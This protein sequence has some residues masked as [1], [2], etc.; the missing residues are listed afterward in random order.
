[1]I[2][3]HA[4]QNYLGDHTMEDVNELIDAFDVE[5]L[6]DD[7]PNDVKVDR[8]ALE[9]F[10]SH[11][12]AESIEAGHPTTIEEALEMPLENIEDVFID[13]RVMQELLGD[14]LAD[15]VRVIL[16]DYTEDIFEN[17]EQRKRAVS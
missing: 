17:M 10:G 11:F 1:M 7:L 4:R 3:Q 5:T 12:S 2:Q 8:E 14:S 16:T 9:E 15:Y 13:E 6:V